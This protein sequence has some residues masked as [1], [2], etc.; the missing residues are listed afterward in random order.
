[1]EQKNIHSSIEWRFSDTFIAAEGVVIGERISHYRILKKLGGGGMGVVY[2]AEDLNLKRHVALKFLPDDLIATHEAL[3]RFRREAQSASGL[4]HPN[5]CTIHEIGEYDG[6]PFGD[7]IV[8]HAAGKREEADIALAEMIKTHQHDAAFQIAEIYAFRGEKD[9][10]FEWLERAYQQRDNGVIMMK[11]DPL[12][13]NLRQDTR[14]TA[15]L[16]KM[17]LPVD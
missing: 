3:E 7:A 15:F 12:L 13:R 5:I 8:Y 16:Q 2:E 11:G 6:R 17:K 14:Y 9:K 1:M 4:N 10:S